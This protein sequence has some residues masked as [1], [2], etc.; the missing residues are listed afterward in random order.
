[1]KGLI[2]ASLLL[3]ISCALVAF[4][5]RAVWFL[6]VAYFDLAASAFILGHLVGE[7]R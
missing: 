6:P 2:G 5:G 1:M 3:V 7:R 4:P